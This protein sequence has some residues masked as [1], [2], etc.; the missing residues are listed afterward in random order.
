MIQTLSC[1][2]ESD[3]SFTSHE[4][5]TIE[6]LRDD[7]ALAAEYL[8]RVLEDGSEQEL[9]L[10]M[11]RLADATGGR[12][13]AGEQLQTECDDALPYVVEQGESRGCEA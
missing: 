3:R 13:E 9:M 4:E 11:R 7:P 5:A 6:S 2:N 1:R 12:S 10:A 8:N